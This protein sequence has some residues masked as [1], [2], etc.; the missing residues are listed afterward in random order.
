MLLKEIFYGF[1]YLNQ[2]PDFCSFICNNVYDPLLL[3]YC[4]AN[5]RRPA[6]SLVKFP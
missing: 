5:I 1:L 4:E 2:I 6:V 3:L